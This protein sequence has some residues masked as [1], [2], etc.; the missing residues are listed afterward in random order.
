MRVKI[1]G[2]VNENKSDLLVDKIVQSLL[3]DTTYQVYHRFMGEIVCE[4][5]YPMEQKSRIESYGFINYFLNELKGNDKMVFL[6]TKADYEYMDINYGITDDYILNKIYGDYYT[7]LFTNIK[8][9]FDSYQREPIN[10][11][12][13]SKRESYLDKIAQWLLDD[14]NIVYLRD[15]RI[16]I[17][18][19]M[20]GSE[21]IYY[22]LPDILD[23]KKEWMVGADD[24]YYIK[25][26]YGITEPDDYIYVYQKYAKILADKILNYLDGRGRNEN[27]YES[28]L[29]Q[30][31]LINEDKNNKLIDKLV[32]V[33]K[34]PYYRDLN[35]MEI[36]YE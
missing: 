27:M 1:K 31:N 2:I 7:I 4:V 34:P 25:N 29:P 14:T 13:Q 11:S 17:M 26:E 6:F 24:R 22:E 19:P 30:N 16:S 5:K 10:E 35:S 8:N 21:D 20:Y 32:N 36:P 15:N 33:I 12:D 28:V 18:F 9:D 3:D 23:I